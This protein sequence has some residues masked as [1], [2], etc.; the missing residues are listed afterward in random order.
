MKVN[1]V[2]VNLERFIP[3]YESKF[4]NGWSYT[5][6]YFL[7]YMGLKVA[8]MPPHFVNAYL[9]LKD[10][11]YEDYI[12]LVFNVRKDTVNTIA[13][14]CYDEYLKKIKNYSFTKII[15][16]NIY[17]YQIAFFY[18]FSDD[19]NYKN[20]SNGAYSKLTDEFKNSHPKTKYENGV[21]ADSV[22]W[23]TFNKSANLKKMWENETGCFIEPEAEVWPLPDIDK[24]SC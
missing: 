19:E 6:L 7:P 2:H 8:N 3:R 13:W 14:R 16:S 11:D 21:L 10:Y 23:M 22:I 18:D 15:G 5:T 1:D 24:E 12:I 4:T 17:E 20:F 9:R